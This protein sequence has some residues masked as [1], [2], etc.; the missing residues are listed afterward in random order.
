MEKKMRKRKQAR[1]W[2][3]PAEY[4]DGKLRKHSVWCIKDGQKRII[5][6]FSEA[7][8]EAAE[9]SLALYIQQKHASAPIATLPASEWLVTDVLSIYLDT[10]VPDHRRPHKTAERILQLS[11]FW[12]GKLL[13]EV[14]GVSCAR[15][16]K[17]RTASPWKSATKVNPH[18]RMV[19]AAAARRELEDLRAAINWHRR[20]GYCR[21]VVEVIL[22]R[23]GNPKDRWLTR[24]E[25][26]KLLWVA[27]TYH[28]TQRGKPTAKRPYRHL[29]RFI[30][31]ALY[32]G[33]RQAVITGAALTEQPGAGYVDLANGRF[34]RKPVD[35]S[36]SNKRSPPI[37]IPP[38]LLCHFQRWAADRGDDTISKKWLIEY[39]GV[40][41]NEVNSGFKAL[42]I[43][44]GFDPEE[45]TPHTLRH[46]AATWLMQSGAEI[47][48][49]A[50]YLGMSVET[51]LRVYGHH[52]PDH[53]KSAVQGFNF[54]PKNKPE[55]GDQR[56]TVIRERK[57][58]TG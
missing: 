53:Q 51:L 29:A 36:E 8:S 7:E 58:N 49:V 2:L 34:Y 23:R 39:N 1:L 28:E 24:T 12:E 6:G 9:K 17:F 21:E 15:Y 19:T 22:P 50:G 38:K 41:V 31:A 54:K 40:K 46:T 26:A 20:N 10:K 48:E 57:T 55:N 37:I 47:W 44:A 43:R 32:T 42:V 35:K 4:Q 16:T 3:K 30:L 11:E 52:H 45:I 5:T 33:S 18:P 25:V 13:S 27:L 14:N 56:G